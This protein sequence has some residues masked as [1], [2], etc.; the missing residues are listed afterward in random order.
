MPLTFQ[1]DKGKLPSFLTASEVE[2][3]MVRMSKIPVIAAGLHM[4][5]SLP[6]FLQFHCADHT[7][8]V[9]GA[10]IVL[11]LVGKLPE[12]D[13]ETLAIAAV[14]HDL[15]FLAATS[16]EPE[17]LYE[18]EHRGAQLAAAS[19]DRFNYPEERVRAVQEM[20][21]DTALTLTIEESTVEQ[22][23]LRNH[24]SPY[25]LD[26]DLHNLGSETF[27]LNLL[28]LFNERFGENVP[29]LDALSRTPAGR[30]FMEDSWK[31]ASHHEWK[32]ESASLLLSDKKRENL[33][34]LR[35]ILDQRKQ[36]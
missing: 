5:N 28:R 23:I 11:A 30:K 24:L 35:R 7:R 20:I 21:L 14:F 29:S 19:M 18:N 31:F 25:L 3:E 9:V 1:Y 13:V 10:V 2:K 4:L 8:S 32:T 27:L 16:G 15:G 6:P 22:G 33:D 17:M 12:A 36:E 34:E 26:A